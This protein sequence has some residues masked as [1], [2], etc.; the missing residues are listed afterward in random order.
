MPPRVCCESAPGAI[1]RPTQMHAA[2]KKIASRTRSNICSSD[3]R[4]QT[5]ERECRPKVR[6]VNFCVL[7]RALP[8]CVTAP[9]RWRHGTPFFSGS[10]V[11]LIYGRYQLFLWLIS[12]GSIGCRRMFR[13]LLLAV[14]P[15]AE[16]RP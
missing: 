3:C 16:E 5:S 10:E 14:R 7:L 13:A 1:A 6:T 11:F 8:R 2:R 12:T 9:Q 4:G 15:D